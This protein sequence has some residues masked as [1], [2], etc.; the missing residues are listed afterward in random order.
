MGPVLPDSLP[1]AP[2]GIPLLPVRV[3]MK[4]AETVT[5][6]TATQL[7]RQGLAETVPTDFMGMIVGAKDH[8]R[9]VAFGTGNL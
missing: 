2:G 7:P 9:E 4:V 8:G 5:R 3:A 6:T 1:A